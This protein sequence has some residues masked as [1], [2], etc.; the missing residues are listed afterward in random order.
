[1]RMEVKVERVDR[2]RGKVDLAPV[3][4]PAP[5]AALTRHA[6]HRGAAGARPPHRRPPGDVHGRRGR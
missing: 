4:E 1:M 3:L 2:L 5:A 6:P